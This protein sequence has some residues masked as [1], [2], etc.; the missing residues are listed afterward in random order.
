[1]KNMEGKRRVA[2]NWP[3]SFLSYLS[4]GRAREEKLYTESHTKATVGSTY[5]LNEQLQL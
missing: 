4:E 5:W 2:C 1:M 3:Q